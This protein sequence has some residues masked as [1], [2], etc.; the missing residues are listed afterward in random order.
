[1]RY[2]QAPGDD[3]CTGLYCAM[4]AP[5]NDDCRQQRVHS[6]PPMLHPV[7]VSHSGHLTWLLQGLALHLRACLQRACTK[8][9]KIAA[10]PDWQERN[11][12]SSKITGLQ[13]PSAKG[14][15][16]KLSTNQYKSKS[17]HKVASKASRTN[18]SNAELRIIHG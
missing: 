13:T 16:N 10:W 6:T 18:R 8:A 7:S 2:D 15:H 12:V 14:C 9:G 17:V 3:V 5:N 1:M 11:Q 4:T